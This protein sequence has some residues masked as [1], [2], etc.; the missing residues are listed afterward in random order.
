MRTL[1]TTFF[2]CLYS[3]FE[4]ARFSLEQTDE[5]WR[6]FDT[7]CKAFEK[8]LASAESRIARFRS[9]GETF[10]DIRNMLSTLKVL[11]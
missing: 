9:D 4:F 10:T 11:M 3:G 5:L 7:D 2:N 6:Q 1:E 8:R